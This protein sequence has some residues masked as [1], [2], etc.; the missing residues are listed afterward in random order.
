MSLPLPIAE[1]RALLSEGPAVVMMA[2]ADALALLD[3][4]ARLRAEVE[5]LREGADVLARQRDRLTIALGEARAERDMAD[6]ARGL[7]DR[8]A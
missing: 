1:W 7:G 5:A 2:K 3:E 8:G 4:I 6:G